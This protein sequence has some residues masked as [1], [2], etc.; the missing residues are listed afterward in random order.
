MQPSE[1]N[2]LGLSEL[3]PGHEQ[4]QNIYLVKQDVKYNVVGYK[5][6]KK[7]FIISRVRVEVVF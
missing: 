5:Q 3:N 1:K 6:K 4:L 7:G 2:C